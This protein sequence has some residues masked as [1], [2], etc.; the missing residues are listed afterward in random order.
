MKKVLI[1]GFGEMGKKL[2][3]ECLRY[4]ENII[5]NAIIDNNSPQNEYKQ[6]PIIR[7]IEICNYI[8]EEIWICT[9]Y[10]ADIIKQLSSI[11][12]IDK[13]K[14]KFV[15]PVVPILEMR[16]R[17][18]YK[19]EIRNCKNISGER[20]EVFEYLQRN[21][22]RMYCY[23]F[24][25]EYLNK[26]TQIKFDNTN[27]LFYGIYKEKRMYLAKQFDTEQKA[28]AYFNG[29]LMEQDA[30]SPHCYWNNAKLC[31][32]VGVGVDI[33]AAEGI[34]ALNIIE[35]VEH[36]Y[37]IE[38]DERWIEALQYTFMSYKN[39]VTILKKFIS[40]TD[41]EDN[42]CLDTLLGDKK[43][44]FIKMDIEG[45]EFQALQGAKNLLTKNKIELAVCVYHHKNDNNLIKQWLEKLGYSCRNSQGLVICQG[46]WELENND[47]DFRKALLYAAKK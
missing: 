14:M 30:R 32:A 31:T 23:S 26:C 36:F 34:F 29:V 44:D 33:G 8:Y 41:F 11:Y 10:F 16:L 47:V 46:E 1:F 38:T 5:I 4:G 17:E 18:K 3:D 9:I 45:V 28:R 24:Y 15:E 6:I 40:D 19:E 21:P 39:K 22:L 27:G 20:K 2:I 37:L 25:D 42:I 12:G 7:P 13:N 43:V 35:Q